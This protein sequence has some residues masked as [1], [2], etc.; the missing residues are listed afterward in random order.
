MSNVFGGINDDVVFV[1]AGPNDA[2]K[3]P[4]DFCAVTGFTKKA[5]TNNK[6]MRVKVFFMLMMFWS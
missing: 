6:E 5:K 4:P 1:G 2:G 3:N